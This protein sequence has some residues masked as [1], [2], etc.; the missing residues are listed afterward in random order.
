MASPLGVFVAGLLLNY[1]DLYAT[2][3]AL[4]I[5]LVCASIMSF[6]S[7]NLKKMLLLSDDDMHGAYERIYPKAFPEDRNIL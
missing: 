4:S 1:L 5:I 7:A 3:I 6:F 2:L